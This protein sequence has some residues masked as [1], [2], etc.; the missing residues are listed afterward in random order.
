MLPSHQRAMAD[1]ERCR[2]AALGGHVYW[3]DDCEEMVY[4]YHSCRNRPCSQGQH[5]AGQEWLARQQAFLLPTPYFMVTFTL[6]EELRDVA[7]SH[8]QLVYDIFFRTSAA[9]LQELAGDPRFVG[10]QL[11]LMGVLQTWARDL[12]Y[13]PHIHYLVPGGGLAGDG[14]TWRPAGKK[15]LAHVKPLSILFR[16]KFR[17]ALKKTELFEQ[18]PAEVWQQGWVVHCQPVGSGERALKYLAP[19]IF[20]VAISNNRLVNLENGQ[21]TFRYRSARRR[22]E[23]YCTL[24]GEEFI[25]RFLQHVLPRGFVKVRY[26]GLFSPAYRPVLHQLRLRLTPPLT[27]A[28]LVEVVAKVAALASSPATPPCPTCGRPM[29]RVQTLKPPQGRSPPLE[30]GGKL[31]A[32]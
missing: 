2:T 8:Q 4:S 31:A 27:E 10:G 24:P 17:D 11:G 28:A 15:F 21:V 5:Q 6:P 13:H 3:C 9:V 32:A 7:R 20:R 22:R 19:Y 29:R 30:Q 23:Q 1:I 18:V 26:Y 12:T 16:A 25:R 14:R